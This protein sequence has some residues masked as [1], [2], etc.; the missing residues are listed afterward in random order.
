M[1]KVGLFT[2]F[3]G[4]DYRSTARALDEKL[5]EAAKEH[6][7]NIDA[8]SIIDIDYNHNLVF[9]KYEDK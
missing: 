2:I 3:K 7:Q 6:D 9:Y 5:A 8:D 1:Y 4:S